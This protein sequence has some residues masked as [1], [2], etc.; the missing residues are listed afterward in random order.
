MSLNLGLQYLT[1]AFYLAIFLVVFPRAIR[2]P[3]G[4]N[5]NVAAFFG[6]SALVIV[7]STIGVV[8]DVAGFPW[9]GVVRGILTMSLPY[10]LLRLVDD[11][12]DVPPWVLRGAEAGLAL[13]VLALLLRPPDLAV[14]VTLLVV[15][16]FVVVTIYDT[17]AFAAQAVRTSGVTRRRMQAVALGSVF[18]AA[19]I[20]M[21][22]LAAALPDAQALWTLLSRSFG[23]ASGL[24][25]YLGFA[26]PAW[27]R[28]AWQFPE[29]QAFLG[30]IAHLPHLPV[31]AIVAE[32]ERWAAATLGAPMA[33]VGVWQE[34]EGVLRFYFGAG[35]GSDAPALP[36]SL[37][38]HGFIT[39]GQ[40][41][42]VPPDRL[43]AGRAFRERRAILSDDVLRDDPD[44]A[45]FYRVIGVRA[46]LAAPITAGQRRLGV[47]AVR[48]LR[49][50][51]FA[52]SD[53]EMVQLLADQAAAVL[54]SHALLEVEAQALAR[55][56]ADRL[57]DEFLASISHDLR[58]PLAAVRGVAQVLERRLERQGTVEPERLAAGLANITA[59]TGQMAS[60][61]DQL[62]DYARLQLH[63]PLD[64]ERRPMD[65]VQ[66]ARRTVSAHQGTSERHR[67]HLE[68]AEPDL[69][70][71]WDHARLE[72]VLQNL[73]GNA[74]KYSPEGG[75]VVVRAWRERVDGAQ[76]AALSVQD[77]G[78]GI[79]A[80]D[81]PHI[82]ERFH[83]ARNVEGR[84][85]GTGIGLATSHQVV[86]QHGGTLTVESREGQ[87]STFT[88]RL[89]LD[90]AAPAS[91]D[92][93]D[94][95]SRA[96]VLPSPSLQPRLNITLQGGTS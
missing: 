90:S 1:W 24:G 79:P 46:V 30:Q 32:I 44:G 51:V 22:G 47:L 64:L 48:S 11:F 54:E 18:L 29:L 94:G 80:A 37:R 78:L 36:D 76:W 12:M 3:T 34:E 28:R 39:N 52:E 6:V 71:E 57:K 42:D 33:A 26:T 45:A 25:F 23:L 10:L 93:G 62:L 43:V 50:P 92:D 53:L 96:E 88:V 86:K 70:G 66:L 68:V 17:W 55:N 87:G 35:H 38:E 77:Q 15:A 31:I 14:P 21:A 82:F 2:R 69:T 16:Y 8:I 13:S 81:L 60:L 40:V 56:E 7:L 67:V 65:L 75:E 83:R 85:A 61:I 27:L 91:H 49:A 58:N 63:R 5:L 95:P 84:I 74:L 9:L 19:T 59:A 20:L 89:P 73:L 4:P 72:R 41:L